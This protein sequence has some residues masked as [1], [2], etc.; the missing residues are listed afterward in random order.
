MTIYLAKY[1]TFNSIQELNHHVDQ[2]RQQT[3]ETE[4]RILWKISNYAVKYIG[5]AHL[6]ASTLADALGVS[7]K[8]IYR[9]LKSLAKKG[10]IEKIAT[11]RKIHGGKGASIIRILPHVPSYLSHCGNEDSL[12]ESRHE[13]SVIQKETA[14]LFNPKTISITNTYEKEFATV[15][16]YDRFKQLLVHTIAA[17]QS[18]ISRLYG[19]YK[20]HSTVLLR[21]SSFT[22][23]QIEIVAEQAL[24]VTVQATKNKKLKNIVGYFNG[25]LDRKLDHLYFDVLYS[26]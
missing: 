20:A 22:Q 3:T 8:T 12:T 21:G 5:A 2:Y 16:F 14:I 15:S 9:T 26:I 10:I 6:K 23:Q 17:D 25:V 13:Q 4:F 1:K 24:K 18:V 11:T 19:V 7:T